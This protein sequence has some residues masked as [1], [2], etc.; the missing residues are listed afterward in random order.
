[1]TKTMVQGFTQGEVVKVIGCV[2]PKDE[3]QANMVGKVLT[4]QEVITVE[5]RQ[6]GLKCPETGNLY[7]F[8]FGDLAK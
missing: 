2:H 6:Y 3:N 7:Y 4:I 8:M 5:Y 1:M